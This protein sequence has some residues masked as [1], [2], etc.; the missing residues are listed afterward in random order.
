M[1]SPGFT[2]LPFMKRTILLILIASREVN[3]LFKKSK[4][5]AFFFVNSEVYF[6][7]FRK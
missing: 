1:L 4:N 2:I 3:V 5:I 6:D 7:M